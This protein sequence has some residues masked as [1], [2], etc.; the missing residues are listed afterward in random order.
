MTEETGGAASRRSPLEG[1]SREERL[2]LLR[3]LIQEGREADQQPLT[4]DERVERLESLA[5]RS[6][7]SW[8]R[9]GR[10]LGGGP[11]GCPCCVLQ[12]V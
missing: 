9:R 7:W 3:L 4:L 1:L 11:A 10:W 12:A 8:G 2:E 5:A 6:P